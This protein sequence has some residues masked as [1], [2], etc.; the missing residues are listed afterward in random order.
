MIM[1]IWV[2]ALVL[3]ACGFVHQRRG[4][5]GCSWDGFTQGV[6]T[7]GVVICVLFGTICA[8]KPIKAGAD[9]ARL[10]AFYDANYRNYGVAVDKTAAYLS[11]GESGG[12]LVAGSLE[13]LELAGF[14]SER[15]KEWRDA[16]NEYNQQVAVY[17][18]YSTHLVVGV[19]YP[20]L[21]DYVKM[22]VIG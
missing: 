8:A 21:P 11:E 6:V 15:M 10:T 20:D 9:V 18:Y 2:V 22:L 19:L 14:I 16:V 5:K 3:L 1:L 4:N 12:A 17:R 7:F 13:K